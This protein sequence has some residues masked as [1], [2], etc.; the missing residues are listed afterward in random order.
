MSPI[1]AIVFFTLAVAFA[2]A[3]T[4]SEPPW[5]FVS[6]QQEA[7]SN[8]AGDDAGADAGPQY[9]V[10][11]LAGTGDAG[12]VDG[13]SD[14]ATFSSPIGI[15]LGPDGSLYVA[16]WSNRRIRKIATD[17]TVSTY[18]GSTPGLA[19]GDCLKEATFGGP[20]GVA[21]DWAGNV[22]VAD[23]DN[24]VIRKIT[25]TST[26]CQVSTL[27]GSGTAGFADDTGKAASFSSPTGVTV[28]ASGNVYVAD[29]GNNKIRKVTPA[30]D[31]TTFAGTGV[32]GNGDGDMATA[33][34]NIPYGIVVDA[35]GILYV[36]EHHDIR[37]ITGG[38][39]RTLAGSGSSGFTDGVGADAAFSGPHGLAIDASGNLYI[40][41]TGNNAVRKILPTGEVTTF[42][43][44][45]DAANKGVVGAADGPA[46]KATFNTPVGVSVD[47]NVVYV[48]DDSNQKIRKIASALDGGLP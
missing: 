44:L 6:D 26:T 13:P 42:A 20:Y 27:A 4:G 36:S 18:A 35:A 45:R 43:G 22:Y 23:R 46:D 30:G 38:M 24:H 21:A 12:A 2:A 17:N 10:T 41:D 5:I 19:N 15:T 47:S 29:S 16:D 25:S 7:G 31:V 28:D 34:F 37:K 48:A 9:V 1:R 39:V 11:T 33:T 40:G 3:C 32:G 14:A 8:D